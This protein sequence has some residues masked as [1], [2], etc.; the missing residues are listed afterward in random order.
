MSYVKYYNKKTRTTYVYEAHNYWDKA[1]KTSKSIRRLIGKIDPS[2]GE[3][4]PTGKRGRPKKADTDYEFTIP[5]HY[6]A[7]IESE[8]N[9]KI[10]EKETMIKEL[11]DEIWKLKE[12]NRRLAAIIE[13]VISITKNAV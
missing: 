10:N 13:S 12:E 8:T 2:T 4:V 1:S 5:E 3:L 6:S 9:E 11:R 7:S